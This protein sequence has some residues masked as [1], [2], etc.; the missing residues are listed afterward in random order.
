[1]KSKNELHYLIVE[2]LIVFVLLISQVDDFV[3]NSPFTILR[4]ICYILSS[5]TFLGILVVWCIYFF[6]LKKK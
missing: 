4:M 1:M 3:S 2:S 5:V 6:N